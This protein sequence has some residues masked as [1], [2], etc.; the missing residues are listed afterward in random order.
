MATELDGQVAALEGLDLQGLRGV[1]QEHFG[2]PPPLRSIELL[3]LNLAWRLQAVAHGGLDPETRRKLGRSGR[4]EAEGL[5]LGIGAV[6]RRRWKGREVEV[7]VERDGFVHDGKRFASLSAVATAI[8][9]TRW[10]GPRFFGL[11]GSA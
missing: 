7:V 1:W 8:A 3:R 6:L 2:D 4:I 5:E 11:R 10:N 9:G